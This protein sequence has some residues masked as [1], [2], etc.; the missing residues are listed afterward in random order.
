MDFGNGQSNM[1]L[2]GQMKQPQKTG[3]SIRRPFA[4]RGYSAPSVPTLIQF[5]GVARRDGQPQFEQ[6]QY[7]GGHITN[8]HVIQQQF[9]VQQFSGQQ[10]PDQELHH[11]PIQG[12]QFPSQ[13]FIASNVY[14]DMVSHQN[15]TLAMHNQEYQDRNETKPRLAKHEVELLERHFQENHKPPSS[16]KRQL[17]EMMGVGVARINVRLQIPTC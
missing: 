13:H 11:G 7:M 9:P 10:L 5:N 14:A 17:A 3:W 2:S 15:S 16:L 4:S 6:Q 1:V 12:S 8:Q